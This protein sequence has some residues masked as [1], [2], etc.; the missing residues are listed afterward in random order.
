MD[1]T[2]DTVVEICYTPAITTNFG[3]NITSLKL[4]D[5]KF[6]MVSRANNSQVLIP[7]APNDMAALIWD[8]NYSQISVNFYGKPD[9]NAKEAI[10][11]A[12]R[13][14]ND[15][16]IYIGGTENSQAYS[17]YPSDTSFYMLTKI[18]LNGNEIWT[19]HYSNNTYLFMN[20]ILATS[21]GGAIMI[22]TSYNQYSPDGQEKDIY[23]VKVDSN[24]NYMTTA[25]N[26]NNKIAKENFIIYPNPIENQIHFRQINVLK[27]YTLEIFNIKG[28]K[29]ISH[30]IS[31]SDTYIDVSKLI[32]GTYIYHLSD[33]EGNF[34]SDKLIKK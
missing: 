12:S 5:E 15:P 34:A 30:Y 23:I 31:K 29:V 9:S 26:E 27:N 1:L 10:N 19:R 13:N 7:T 33:N 14:K 16:F 18:D 20:K 6:M 3:F 4:S 8:T 28:Q 24:G 22:G 11:T 2:L 21:D 17:P 25:I 32:S